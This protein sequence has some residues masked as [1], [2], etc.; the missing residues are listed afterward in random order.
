[1]LQRAGG[2]RSLTAAQVL[3]A[4]Q[5]TAIPMAAP[6][7]FSSGAGFIQADRAVLNSFLA[8]QTGSPGNDRLQGTA[9]SENL[10]GGAGDDLLLGAGGLDALFGGTGRD[11]LNGG[12]GN[13]YL[14]GDWGN[15]LLVGGKGNDTLEGGQGNDTL[16]GGSGKNQLIG[17]RGRDVFAIDARGMARIQDFRNGEDKLGVVKKL[18]FSSLSVVQRGQSAIVQFHGETLA[19]L[20]HTKATTITSADFKIV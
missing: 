15:D 14:V 2:H 11:R 3:A 6:G 9:V 13:D 20:L 18:K 8:Q 10:D 5:S 19:A 12:A 1:M 7:N 16:A 4:L 17:D